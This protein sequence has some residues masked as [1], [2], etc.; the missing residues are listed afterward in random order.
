MLLKVTARQ[1]ASSVTSAVHCSSSLK[2]G[3]DSDVIAQGCDKKPHRCPDSAMG[4]LP[5][6]GLRMIQDGL[7]PDD[8]AEG[9]S[10]QSGTDRH[11]TAYKDVAFP[12]RLNV[13]ISNFL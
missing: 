9:L 2:P 5:P 8:F 6:S 13:A 7:C 10:R 11:R 12:L 1:P 3:R 4:T